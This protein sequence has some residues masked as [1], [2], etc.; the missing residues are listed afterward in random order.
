MKDENKTLEQLLSELDGLENASRI[1]R[2]MKRGAKIG[3]ALLAIVIAAGVVAAVGLFIH[4]FPAVPAAALGTSCT[5]LSSSVVL[6]PSGPSF[7]VF[8]CQAATPAITVNVA[9]SPIPTFS[10]SGTGYTDLLIFRTSGAAPSTSCSSDSITKTLTSSVAVG[11][12]A[13]DVGGWNYCADYITSGSGL[14]TFTV[15]WSQ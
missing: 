14:G 6:A 1:R 5:I 9:S 8:S 10:L 4:T 2:P 15:S 11:F 12:V 3:I 13:G 7:I